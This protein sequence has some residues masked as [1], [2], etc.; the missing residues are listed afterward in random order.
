MN[1]PYLTGKWNEVKGSIREKWG[2][3]TDSDIA[4]TKGEREQL[5]G[6]IQQAYGRDRAAAEKELSEWEEEVGLR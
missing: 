2:E 6:K 4:E 3:L 1:T 5:L